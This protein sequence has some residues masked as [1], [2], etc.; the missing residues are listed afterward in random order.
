MADWMD[1]YHAA[2]RQMVARKGVPVAFTYPDHPIPEMRVSTYGW[3]HFDA[4]DHAR[5]DKCAWKIPDDAKIEEQS[6]SEFLD[7]DVSNAH[8][9]G[10]N[11]TPAACSCGRYTDITLRVSTSLGEALAEVTAAMGVTS[12]A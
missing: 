3:Q 5:R 8:T 4:W 7:T 10:I 11:V 1:E 12:G 6:Y 9:M 2:V